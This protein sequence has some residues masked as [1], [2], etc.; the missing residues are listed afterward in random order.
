MSFYQSKVA[1]LFEPPQRV[2][3]DV[4]KQLQAMASQYFPEF[5]FCDLPEEGHCQ[6]IESTP[7]H[8]AATYRSLC[9]SCPVQGSK[10]F[11]LT[12]R[13]DVGK[14]LEE[15]R[16]AWVDAR[17]A[18]NNAKKASV[19]RKDH[20]VSHPI[21]LAERSAWIQYTAL[22]VNHVAPAVVEAF[23]GQRSLASQ[24]HKD[25]DAF[26][27]TYES[28]AWHR[29]TVKGNNIT[30]IWCWQHMKPGHLLPVLGLAGYHPEC[31]CCPRDVLEDRS[32][33]RE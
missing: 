12:F 19:A 8:P 29:R 5:R 10:L 26:V 9:G 22:V 17:D 7:L 24:S 2:P 16:Q 3:E 32:G 23:R 18:L 31:F 13:G 20:V 33:R 14:P 1:L 4:N 27:H 11:D 30:P 28:D 6:L 15:T 25:Y 21:Q